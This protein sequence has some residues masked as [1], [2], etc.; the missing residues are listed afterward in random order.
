MKMVKSHETKLILIC[1]TSL[2][3]K[4]KKKNPWERENSKFKIF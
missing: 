1:I 3:K 4:K 2:I